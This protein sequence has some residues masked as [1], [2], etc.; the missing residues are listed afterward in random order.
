VFSGHL[1]VIIGTA[2][3]AR[4][5]ELMPWS[6]LDAYCPA[7]YTIQRTA[8]HATHGH[9]RDRLL[10]LLAAVGGGCCVLPCASTHLARAHV[11]NAVVGTG[12]EVGGPVG[13]GVGVDVDGCGIRLRAH[14]STRSFFSGLVCGSP[15]GWQEQ[16]ER[17]WPGSCGW[18]AVLRIGRALGETIAF[19]EYSRLRCVRYK[20]SERMVWRAAPTDKAVA[21]WVRVAKNLQ[22][23]VVHDAGHIV[24]YQPIPIIPAP[25]RRILSPCKPGP[26]RCGCSSL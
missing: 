23:V 8:H 1:D 6:G 10:E 20:A 19:S 18:Q 3:T 9:S 7:P 25:S 26:N 14:V 2:L 15:S 24:P 4:F 12:R 11:G 13:I 16:L 5:L 22:F 21:G 17:H